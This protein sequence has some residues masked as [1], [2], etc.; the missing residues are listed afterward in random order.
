MAQ[1]PL[2]VHRRPGAVDANGSAVD[3]WWLI[4]SEAYPVAANVSVD[5][6]AVGSYAA[7]ADAVTRAPAGSLLPGGKGFAVVVPALDALWL[8]ATRA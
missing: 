2:A 6:A 3:H 7:V 1:G 8:R 4:N 5:A